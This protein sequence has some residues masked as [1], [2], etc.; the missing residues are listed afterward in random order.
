MEKRLLE[1]PY[2]CNNCK[3]DFKLEELYCLIKLRT[4]TKK[5]L[6]KHV[7]HLIDDITTELCCP[8]CHKYICS[9]SC[10]IYGQTQIRD[11]ELPYNLDERVYWEET[12]KPVEIT[13]DII[14]FNRNF[15][16]NL[17][18][19]LEFISTTDVMM[20]VKEHEYKKNWT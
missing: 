8:N 12:L 7:S 4:Y 11:V 18:K 13:Q 10:N 2:Y 19:V 14:D 6:T 17:F 16:K 9:R 15:N 20:N 3:L 1:Y 5:D